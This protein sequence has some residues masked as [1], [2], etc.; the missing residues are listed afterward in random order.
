M[1]VTQSSSYHYHH[2]IYTCTP[3]IFTVSDF[4]HCLDFIKQHIFAYFVLQAE[5]LSP[6]ILHVL[7]IV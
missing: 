5:L 4:V 6:Y 3:G 2:Q 1:N 7:N